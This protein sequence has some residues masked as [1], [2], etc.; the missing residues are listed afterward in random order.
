[1]SLVI[2][3]YLWGATGHLPNALRAWWSWWKYMLA[4]FAAVGGFALVAVAIEAIG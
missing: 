4:A 2:P 3:L 1:M